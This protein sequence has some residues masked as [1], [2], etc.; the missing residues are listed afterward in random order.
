MALFNEETILIA[1]LGPWLSLPTVSVELLTT[2]HQLNSMKEA[3]VG[4][5]SPNPM[6]K[7]K[8]L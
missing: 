2:M 8:V 6:T 1:R 3:K 5:Y 4:G 7:Q